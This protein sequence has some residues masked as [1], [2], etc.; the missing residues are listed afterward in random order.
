LRER[1]FGEIIHRR[2][3]ST[4]IRNRLSE[5]DMGYAEGECEDRREHNLRFISSVGDMLVITTTYFSHQVAIF[6]F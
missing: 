3:K 6:R 4:E 2:D 1:K 5:E